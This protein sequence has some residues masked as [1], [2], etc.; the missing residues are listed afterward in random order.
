MKLL[1]LV[2]LA[3]GCFGE[4]HRFQATEFYNT[5]SGAHKPALRV[6]PGDHVITSTIDARGFDS[7]GVQRNP[8]G[9]PEIGPFF[10]EGSEPGDTLVVHLLMKTCSPFDSNDRL[11][12]KLEYFARIAAQHFVG[13][14]VGT[15]QLCDGK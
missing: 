4:T 12:N 10:I 5:F 15:K 3:V 8:G 13:C 6:K 11:T 1:L 2:A 14:T 7:A 9:N